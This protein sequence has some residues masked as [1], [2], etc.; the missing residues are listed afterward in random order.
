MG[1][2][3]DT[4]VLNDSS[5][6]STIVDLSIDGAQLLLTDRRVIPLAD[7]TTVMCMSA[8]AAGSVVV[9]WLGL[10]GQVPGLPSR[11]GNLA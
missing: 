8:L 1:Q 6:H 5:C 7:G 2:P 11:V 10:L 9:H 4:S 3:C